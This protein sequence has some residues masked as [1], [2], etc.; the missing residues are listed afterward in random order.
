MKTLLQRERPNEINT[1]RAPSVRILFCGGPQDG[2][3]A[4]RPSC[5]SVTFGQ[6]ADPTLS[7][8]DLYK[9]TIDLDARSG[10][11]VFAYEGRQSVSLTPD[12]VSR[13]LLFLGLRNLV[14]V[15]V[16]NSKAFAVEGA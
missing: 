8:F 6:H 2:R 1:A 7:V 9:R 14:A 11:T 16:G 5:E 12:G 13:S 15:S 3:T 10:R 4:E